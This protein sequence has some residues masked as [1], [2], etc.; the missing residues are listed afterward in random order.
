MRFICCLTLLLCAGAVTA[1]TGNTVVNG[2]AREVSGEHLGYRSFHP[3]ATTSLLTRCVDGKSTIRWDTDPVPANAS[4]D[5]IEF[6]WVAAHSSGT[7]AADATFHLSLNGSE[8]LSFTTKKEQPLRQWTVKGRDGVTLSFDTKWEDSVNDLYGYMHCTVPMKLLTKGQP[9]TF[10]ITGENANRRDWYMTFKYAIRDSL[11]IQPQPAILAGTNGNKQIIDVLFDVIEPASSAKISVPGQ[12]SMNVKLKLGFN[13]VQFT[14]D[15]VTVPTPVR[16]MITR[17]GHPT[18][19]QDVILK[20]VAHRE[21]WMVHHSHND[22]G[23]SDLQVD[24]EKK[25]LKNLRDAMALYRKTASYP[26]EARFKWNSE[27][28]WAVQSF[29]ET[30]TEAEKKEFIAIVKEGGI[31]LNAFYTNP[32]TG[33]RAARGAH[34]DHRFRP[35]DRH[36]VRRDGE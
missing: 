34:Q 28:M 16:V 4:G 13:Q 6:V 14:V 22:I 7:S 27:I 35:E 26:K 19:A 3:Y 32:L 30:A 24:V 9:V 17:P 36:G 2:Y 21:L 18:F 12:E 20:P 11:A 25:Q 10:G 33:D 15:A 5:A 29:L 23:Y 1:Y 31:G 8:T